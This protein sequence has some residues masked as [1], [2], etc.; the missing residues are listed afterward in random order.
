[1]KKTIYLSLI[2]L[3]TLTNFI[4][5]TVIEKTYRFENYRIKPMGYF[6]I[7]ELENTKVI[8]ETGKPSIPYHS[9]ALLL[10]PTEAAVSIEIERTEEVKIPYPVNL[11]PKQLSI[12]LSSD[13]QIHFMYN[14][15]L[16]ESDI[17]YPENPL[18]EIS[19]HFM[20]G[21]SIALSVFTPLKYNPKTKQ[22]S[23]YKNVKI[24]IISEYTEKA[25]AALYN[26]SSKESVIK[27]IETFSHNPEML[28]VYPTNNETKENNF[29]L[30]IVTPWKYEDQFLEFSENYEELGIKANIVSTDLIQ[31]NGQGQDLAEKIRNY[32]ISTYQESQIE[33]VLLGGD[34]EHVPY[35][36]FYATVQSDSLMKDNNIPADIYFSALDGTWNDDNDSLWGEKN[37]DDLLPEIAVGRLPFSDADELEN[38]LHKIYSYQFK[39]VPGEIRKP[40]FV[41]EHLW[42]NPETWGSDYLELLIGYKDDNGY[43][44]RGIPEDFEIMKMYESEFNW[45]KKDLLKAINSGTSF[46]HHVG[47]SHYYFNMKFYL[48]DINNS[49]FQDVDGVKHNYPLVYSHGCISGAFDKN[50]C[51]GERMLTIDNFAVAYIGNSRYGWFNEGQTDGPSQ[52]LHREFLDAIYGEGFFNLGTV[53]MKSKIDTAPWVNAPGQHEDGA[54]RWCFYDN[55]VLGDPSMFIWPDEPENL[56]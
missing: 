53:H 35:R 33:Y 19:T 27:R 8:G 16:Y 52:H 15:N 37:E 36:G 42:D 26:L 20:N 46:I 7:I 9:I 48:T 50:D 51:I 12:P 29:D 18:G 1:M 39:P 3:L 10:P 45:S 55:N 49:N 32:I 22:A 21:H 6:D 54:L 30:L 40:L 24:K 17:S 23:Y 11:F 13:K 41:G 28:Q 5:A 25:H 43:N 38:I 47:H 34:V 14:P 31:R 44:T 56:Y 4:Y 2:F